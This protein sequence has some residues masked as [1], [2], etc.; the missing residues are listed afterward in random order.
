MARDDRF[1]HCGLKLFLF[2]TSNPRI[3]MAAEALTATE[4]IT[5]HL[6]HL[7]T[8]AQSSIIDFSVINVDTIVFSIL[9]MA[10]ALYLM[11]KGALLKCSLSL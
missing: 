5:H 8:T 10:C 6:H 9:M 7:S 11:Y 2:G 3:N 1:G 4:Y